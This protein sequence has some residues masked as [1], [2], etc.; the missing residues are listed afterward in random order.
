MHDPSGELEDDYFVAIVDLPTNENLDNFP[1]FVEWKKPQR[2]RR[3]YGPFLTAFLILSLVF[4]QIL[5]STIPLNERLS[6]YFSRFAPLLTHSPTP[7]SQLAMAEVNIQ[8]QQPYALPDSVHASRTSRGALL[9]I[10]PARAPDGCL[11]NALVDSDHKMTRSPLM[12][13]G[14]DGPLATVHL[15]FVKFPLAQGWKGWEVHLQLTMMVNDIETLLLSTGNQWEGASPTFATNN[16][17]STSTYLTLDYQHPVN[18]TDQPVN[19]QKGVWETTLYI[20]ASG[21]YYLNATWPAGR[22]HVIFSAGR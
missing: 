6:S 14:F 13:T 7:P 11:S 20:P 12:I 3:R 22:W 19:K 18:A 21:C 1:T 4:L 10:L 2:L 5:G 9:L 17:Q 8:P 16:G 15:T